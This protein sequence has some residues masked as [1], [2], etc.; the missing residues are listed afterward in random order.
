MLLTRSPAYEYLTK[1]IV[2]EIT[3]R[4]RSIPQEVKLGKREGLPRS[5]VA[6][7]DNVHVIPKSAL[8]ERAGCLASARQREVKQALG[9]ALGWAELKVL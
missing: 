4:I 3:T 2:C 8:V 9:Y 6:N 1:I 5:S 7:L